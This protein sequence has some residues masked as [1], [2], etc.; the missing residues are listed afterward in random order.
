MCHRYNIRAT[1]AEIASWFGAEL[2]PVF[3]W[4]QKTLFPLVDVPVILDS[5]TGRICKLMSWGLVPS[6]WKPGKKTWKETARSSFNARS[7][8]VHE[9]PSFRKAF[10][11]QR[12][13]IPATS[14]FE[15]DLD[16]R[17]KDTDHFAM[18]GLWEVCQIDGQPHESCTILT[19]APNSCVEKVH[20]RMPVILDSDDKIRQ[21]LSPDIHDREPLEK[22]FEPISGDLMQSS[23]AETA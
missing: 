23:A 4:P 6:W 15:K 2:K 21:W 1:S 17:L 11:S 12:C 13:L 20:H 5:T 14:F 9:K 10:K 8:T 16:F 7:E 3:D 22:L 18:A 19:T